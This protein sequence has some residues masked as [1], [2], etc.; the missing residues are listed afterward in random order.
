MRS[1]LISMIVVLMLPAN[2]A[3]PADVIPGRWDLVDSL[4]P[5][6][7]IVVRLRS[8]ERRESAFITSGPEAIILADETGRESALP[9]SEVLRIETAQKHPDRLRNGAWI[10][11]AVGCGSAMLALLAYAAHVT[12]SGPIWGGE[13]TGLYI[14]GGMTGAGIGALVGAGIDAAHKGGAVLYRAR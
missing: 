2:A 11:T 8:H 4:T 5:G 1:T 6:T 3:L 14:L 13:S 9:K 10:G 12:A 7:G